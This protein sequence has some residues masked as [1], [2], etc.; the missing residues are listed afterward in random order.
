MKSLSAF[1]DYISRINRVLD[2]IEK[3]LDKEFT[4]DELAKIANFSKF[5]FHR[6]FNLI[7]GENLFQYI[8]RTRIEKG[9]NFLISNPKKTITQI[10]LDCG[11]SNS[12]SFARC[13]KKYFKMSAINFRKNKSNQSII[14]SNIRKDKNY[15]SMYNSNILKLE[16]WRNSKGISSGVEVKVFPE[17]TVVYL[18]YLGKM[19]DKKIFKNLFK[20]LYNW[21]SS[22][23][24][25][26]LNSKGMI[27]YHN[28]PE[29]TP[30]D[31]MMVSVCFTVS[32]DTEVSGEIGKL[33]IPGGKYAFARFKISPEEFQNA[34]SWLCCDWLP[35]S[36]YEC[37]DRPVFDLYHN[38]PNCLPGEK[39]VVDICIPVIPA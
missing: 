36:G 28:N 4:L 27:I 32:P 38:D 25:L 10:A 6:I 23:D 19:N 13:F 37:D 17:T 26:D 31:K 7:I 34:W 39:F 33:V 12:S 22:R 15:L 29:I 35:Q 21:A 2:Y 24:L 16:S 20:N 11:F 8:Q 30:E 14:N 5:H 3:N 1:E 18:R 9:A